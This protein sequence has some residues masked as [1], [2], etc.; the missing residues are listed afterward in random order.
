MK[1]KLFALSAYTLIAASS[2]PVFGADAV[3]TD[4]I[5]ASFER[6]LNH[7]ATFTQVSVPA[8]SNATADPLRERLTVLLWEEPSYHLPVWYAFLQTMPKPSN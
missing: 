2:L 4:Q 3:A 8:A 1:M 5:S 6:L 7:E